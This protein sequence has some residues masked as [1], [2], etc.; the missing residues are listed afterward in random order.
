MWGV[1]F[2]NLFTAETIFDVLPI[3]SYTNFAVNTKSLL[4]PSFKI[5]RIFLSLSHVHMLH[6]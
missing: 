5:T 2:I 3:V 6:L 1:V 4:T